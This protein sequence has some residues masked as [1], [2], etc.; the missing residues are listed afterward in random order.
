M[1]HIKSQSS[2]YNGK[3][4]K[5]KG[6]TAVVTST[7]GYSGASGVGDF[8]W[9]ASCTIETTSQVIAS[10][11]YKLNSPLTW[12]ERYGVD[13]SSI[14]GV[15]WELTTLSFVWDWFFGIG[16][17]LNSLRANLNPKIEVLGVSV[18][19]RVSK[20]LIGKLDKVETT[21]FVPAW[22]AT[23]VAD[24]PGSYTANLASLQRVCLPPGFNTVFPALNSKALDL[25]KSIDLL[26]LIYQRLK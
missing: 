11:A 2:G 4:A 12:Q 14:P 26:C 19:K 7:T 15:A 22:T 1:E 24:G 16:T 6:K 20:R 17:W 25:Q 3:M 8:K 9:Y 18:S 21:V 13:M 5:R 10:V 23:H